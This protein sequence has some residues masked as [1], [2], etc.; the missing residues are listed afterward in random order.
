MKIHN[1]RTAIPSGSLRYAAL[2]FFLYNPGRFGP[3][4]AKNGASGLALANGT[5]RAPQCNLPNALAKT[6]A[7]S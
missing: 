5:T 4:A 1:K 6:A 7:C 2:F 3:Q